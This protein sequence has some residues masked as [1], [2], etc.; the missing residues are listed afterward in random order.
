MRMR[1]PAG[2]LR[3]SQRSR[4]ALPRERVLEAR[5][6]GQPLPLQLAR[7]IAPLLVRTPSRVMRVRLL[8][9]SLVIRTTE[10]SCSGFTRT[11]GLARTLIVTAC[12]DPAPLLSTARSRTVCAPTV[13][14]V[15]AATLPRASS[16]WPSPSRSQVSEVRNPSE[17]R[18][19]DARLTVSPAYGW[20]GEKRIRAVGGA[21]TTTTAV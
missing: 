17:S 18:E 4:T 6:D 20:L 19:A 8:P 16:N 5:L 9:G 21:F 11:T 14:K 12:T 3:S 1:V 15:L 10:S 13:V 7:T 2:M